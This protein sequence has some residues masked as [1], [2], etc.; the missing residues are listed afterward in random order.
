[1]SSKSRRFGSTTVTLDSLQNLPPPPSPRSKKASPKVYTLRLRQRSASSEQRSR[2]KSRQRKVNAE[3]NENRNEGKCGD[4]KSSKKCSNAKDCYWNSNDESCNE[5]NG[6]REALMSEIKTKVAAL[7]AQKILVRVA[8]AAQAA[9]ADIKEAEKVEEAAAGGEVGGQRRW[10]ELLLETVG[11]AGSTATGAVSQTFS[12]IGGILG[13]V[14]GMGRD[15]FLELIRLLTDMGKGL[16]DMLPDGEGRKAII[17]FLHDIAS[18]TGDLLKYILYGGMSGARVATTMIIELVK[19][20]RDICVEFIKY[21]G[22]IIIKL[23]GGAIRLGGDFIGVVIK[24]L[25]SIV[26]VITDYGPGALTA[27]SVMINR[28]IQTIGGTLKQL[29]AAAPGAGNPYGSDTAPP[30]AHR[31]KPPVHPPHQHGPHIRKRRNEVSD[32]EEYT[33]EYLKKPVERSSGQY[34]GQKFERMRRGG[35]KRFRKNRSSRRTRRRH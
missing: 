1:M 33:A 30:G 5:K 19:G 10:M 8:T 14:G 6:E 28:G 12:T 26:T 4:I 21:I 7:A 24:F 23:G 3:I 2:Q 15:G 17:K 32:L 34:P 16:F 27:V 35:S 18:Q 25:E 22:P 20:I 9:P 13:E 29:A 11:N 31:G